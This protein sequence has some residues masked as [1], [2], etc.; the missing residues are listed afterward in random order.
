MAKNDAILSLYE[1]VSV[2]TDQMLQA[3]QKGDWD[4]LVVLE[5]RCS[6]HVEALMR[7]EPPNLPSGEGRAAKVRFIQ[8][9][10]D[11]DQQ[12][13]DLVQPWMVQLGAMINSS[14][15]QRKL[16]QAYGAPAR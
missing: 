8:K 1:S 13:R 11:A 9:I 6:E 2:M 3:A 7:H 12:I 4:Q 14:G 15:T 16:V 5:T 10:L